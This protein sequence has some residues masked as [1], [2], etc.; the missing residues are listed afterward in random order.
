VSRKPE[1]VDILPLG[2]GHLLRV[3]G[4]GFGVA[5]GVGSMIG[6]GIL[7]TPGAI[8]DRVP[9]PNLI[10]LLWLLGGVHALL[11]ANVVAELMTSMPRSGG[12]YVAAR[13]AFGD[14][15]GLLVGWADW[16]FSTASTAGLAIAA[17]E[18]MGLIVPGW[19]QYTTVGAV[20]ILGTVVLLNWI[21]V[22]EG[23]VTQQVTSALKCLLLLGI[24]GAVFMLAPAAPT[25]SSLAPSA[26]G[27]LLAFAVAYQFIFTAYSG[28]QYPAYFGDEDTKPSRN[29]PRS[30][31]GSAALVTVVYLLMNLTL[32][33]ALPME[34]LRKAQLPI[35]LPLAEIL[36]PLSSTLIAATA[37]VIVISCLNGTVML[38]PRILYGLGRDGLFPRFATRVNRGGTPDLGLAVSALVALGLTLSGSYEKVFLLSGVFGIFIFVMADLSLFVL[39]RR[40][41]GLLRPYRAVGYPWL[42]ALVLLIDV[43]LFVAFLLA[44]W[45]SGLFMVAAAAAS[46]PISI[47]IRRVRAREAGRAAT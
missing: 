8:A 7:R 14:F 29:I 1:T 34:V 35:S 31:F 21:G 9:E 5:L 33:H 12:I 45:R 46:L 32:L 37:A 26:P 20:A 10:L 25:Q 22:R 43:C 3:L 17:S 39:R 28:W 23:S 6:G 24:I 42:P 13:R 11:G 15:G 16:L 4:L 38:M 27:M 2:R 19:A 36:G 40:E 30:L 18:F 44:D 41:P 47:L